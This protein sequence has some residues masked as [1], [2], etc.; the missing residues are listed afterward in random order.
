MKSNSCCEAHCTC[1]WQ[2]ILEPWGCAW[3]LGTEAFSAWCTGEGVVLCWLQAEGVST[4]PLASGACRRGK[5]ELFHLIF[6]YCN[7][8]FLNRSR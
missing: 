4:F 1:K 6:L 3:F 5:A 7:Y 8:F 2:L